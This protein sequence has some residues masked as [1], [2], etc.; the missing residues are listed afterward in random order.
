M[1]L[2]VPTILLP[3]VRVPST[4]STLL[5]FIVCVL[6][7]SFEKNKNKQNDAGFGNFKKIRITRITNRVAPVN[8]SHFNSALNWDEFVFSERR[9]SQKNKKK[10]WQEVWEK[11]LCRNFNNWWSSWTW[12]S[13][14]Q[15][16]TAFN[17]GQIPGREPCSSGYGTPP[18]FQRSWVQIPAPYTGWTQHFFTHICCK[19]CNVCLKRWKQMKKRQRMAQFL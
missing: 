12:N 9:K 5:S 19:N 8:L 7:L 4:P 15:K 10:F 6:Y 18:A 16:I 3:W 1:D 11:L 17:L 14:K 13:S 2:S